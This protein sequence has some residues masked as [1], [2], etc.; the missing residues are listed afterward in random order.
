MTIRYIHGAT[1]AGGG[2]PSC[3][4]SQGRRCLKEILKNEQEFAKRVKGDILSRGNSTCNWHTD[5]KQLGMFGNTKFKNFLHFLSTCSVPGL[6]LG[7]G[8]SVVKT[9]PVSAVIVLRF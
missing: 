9:Q 5:G 4:A 8:D 3:E 6:V 7:P 2:T 1:E